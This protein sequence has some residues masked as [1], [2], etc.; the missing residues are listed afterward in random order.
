M[1]KRAAVDIGGTFTDLVSLDEETGEIILG[2]TST[3]PAHF[4]EGVITAITDA[5]LQGVHFLAHGTTVIINAL[6]ERKGAA[7]AL[8]TTRGFRDILE[9]QRA[10]RPDL[11]N[12]VYAKPKPFVPRRLRLEITE[13][14][15]YKGEVL[16][17]LVKEDVLAAVEEA[18]KQGA[19]AIA[20]CFLHA[21]ANPA[22]EKQACE[23]IKQVWPEV[24]VSVS[25]E[26]AQEWR[27]FDRS[28]TTVLDAYVKPT[29]R[30]YLHALETKLQE[31][32]IPQQA[33]YVMQSNGGVTRFRMASH[34]PIHLVES[35]PVGGI[36]GAAAIGKLIGEPNLITLDIGGTTAKSSLIE[37]GTVK[38]TSD[39][40][41]ERTPTSAGYPIKVPVV[42]IIEI[43]AGGGSIAWI[44]PAGALKVGPRSAGADPGP[45]AYGRG[46]T[47]PTVTDASI[48]TG[49]INPHYFLGG[50][51]KLDLDNARKA[52]ARIADPLGVSIEEA[53]LGI[54]R[55]A[56]ANMTH[57][58][59][60]VSVRQ[61][62]D[63][64]EFAMVAC[65]G[66]GSLHAATLAKE[67][68]IPRVIVPP[69]PGHF[70]AWGMLMS[71]LRHD[72]VQTRLLR[73]S[74][75]EMSTLNEIFQELEQRLYALFAEEGLPEQEILFA[76]SADMRYLGQE[77][78]VNVPIPNGLLTEEHHHSLESLFHDLHEQRYTFR[79][80]SQIEIVHLRLTGF[81]R[82]RKPELRKIERQSDIKRAFK[83]VRL[84]DFDDS[85]QHETSIYDRALLGAG[86]KL[87][88]PAVIEET[89]SST[90]V[91]PGQQASID[92]Y[93]N[94]IIETG[95][96]A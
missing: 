52:M 62:R 82:V 19:E 10:N 94:I 90:L 89:A 8:L 25:H 74:Q 41:I 26:L 24:D 67:L 17:P 59:K 93:G 21:Y 78:T 91:L 65:G 12:L 20:I 70:S 49:R 44:D 37:Q 79:Q 51:L 61:G 9:I 64:R 54:I 22:H 58:L 43:G 5:Q 36:I 39:Y 2:K 4:E 57:L 7:T 63:P 88:G 38:V 33:C 92:E 31:V 30:R 76:R 56:N 84:V 6:T 13:R 3:T 28:S 14:I 85:G 40:F 32:N 68:H 80:A 15:N 75:M 23:L 60:L 55:I 35:G 83:G 81:G 1:S 69:A 53:A 47:E 66:G 18:R 86:A 27:E 73:T 34:T 16:T 29:A 50:K 48:L 42:D 87:E 95:G 72:V 46:G 11:Y 45:A 71:D 77:H 96:E